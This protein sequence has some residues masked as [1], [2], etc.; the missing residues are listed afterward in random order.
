MVAHTTSGVEA[1]T[2]LCYAGSM[3]APLLEQIGLSPNEAKIY[4]ALMT[5]GGSGVS[6]ISSRAKVHRR[7]VYDTL[8]RLLQKGLVYEVYTTKETAYHAVDPSKLIELAQERTRLVEGSLPQMLK[9]FHAL[10]KTESSYIYKG[11]EGVKNYMRDTLAVGEDI[12]VL[13]AK[14]AWFDSRLDSYSGWY[15]EEVK[16][17]GMKIN[18]LYDHEVQEKMPDI[19]G[20]LGPYY[21]FLPKGYSTESAMDIF[22]DHILTYSGLTLGKWADDLTVFVTISPKLAEAQR[23]WWKMMWDMLPNPP[24][25][26]KH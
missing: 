12:Y 3:F 24:K 23:I 1:I 4:E 20:K 19:P 9:T 2:T 14:G 18:I 15:I 11:I 8:Q 25:K 6:S 10:K 22:G 26:R 5:Y 13:G 7:N 16:K 17:R 21:K